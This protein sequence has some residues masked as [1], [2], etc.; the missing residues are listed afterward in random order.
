LKEEGSLCLRM[1]EEK[2]RKKKIGKTRHGNM[3]RAMPT[4]WKWRVWLGIVRHGGATSGTGRAKVLVTLG[5]IFFVFLNH[6]WTI[7]YKTT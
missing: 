3:A 2:E 6:A 1:K 5:S 7:T 4:F